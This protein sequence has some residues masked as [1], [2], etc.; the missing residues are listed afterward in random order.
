MGASLNSRCA[1]SKKKH[2]LGLGRIADLG[3][4]LEQLR[5]QPQQEGRVEPRVLHQLVGGE[6][7]DD[8]AAVAVGADEVL[9]AS[10]AGSPKN[11][12]PPWFSSTSSWR[13]MVPT[14]GF[15]T[16]PYWVVS[17]AACSAT[18]A[19]HRAQV[20]EVEQQQPLLVG[21]A[22]ADVEH[23]LLHLVEIEQPRQQQR[24][25][26]R[27]GG[28][29]RMALL[30]EQVP[31]HDREL[32][33]LVVEA[34]ALGARDEGLLGLA[35]RGDAGEIA[36]DVG[37]EHRNAGARKPSASTCRVTV[38]PV[39][40]AP[41]TSP[42]RLASARVRN[43]GLLPLPTKIV[44]SVSISDIDLFLWLTISLNAIF[45]APP[46]RSIAAADHLL[47]FSEGGRCGGSGVRIR[48]AAA[49]PAI[50]KRIV[51]FLPLTSRDLIECEHAHLLHE[52]A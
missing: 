48:L 3:Q 43:S 30:A 37:G 5:Q 9:R 16:L 52:A 27:D 11:L 1:S 2:E 10:S 22:E 13:W 19:E 12:V 4:L 49:T 36:L 34:E 24:S 41:V 46:P 20:L 32:V 17:S 33:G 26:L 14:V 45:A 40:V 42:C 39:P 51:L 25:H 21:D 47:L 29:D 28:A 38:L 8:A 31:E 35:R 18:I 44:P 15:D 6:D 50:T 7:I 23:A